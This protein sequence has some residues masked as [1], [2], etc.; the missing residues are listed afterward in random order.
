MKLKCYKINE[1]A[2]LP[3]YGS[4]YAACFDISV[5]LPKGGMPVLVDK[6]RTALVNGEDSSRYIV[7]HPGEVALVPTGLIFDIPEGYQMKILP[8]SGLAWKNS[9]TVLNSPGT[10]DED[11]YNET[12]VL[13]YNSSRNLPFRIQHG[14]RIAQGEIMKCNMIQFEE[15]SE[16]ELGISKELLESSRDGGLGSTGMK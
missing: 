10:I 4:T 2:K 11:Y 3:T 14:D 12:F 8:R 1:E 6:N 15:I 13:L 7:I 9:I 16:L 5:C